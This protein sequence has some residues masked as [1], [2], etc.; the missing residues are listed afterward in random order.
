MKI[1]PDGFTESAWQGIIDAKDIA[2]HENH[3]FLES[4]HLFYSLLKKNQIAIKK[5]KQKK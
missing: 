2:S 3:Q 4:E 1:N 5:R